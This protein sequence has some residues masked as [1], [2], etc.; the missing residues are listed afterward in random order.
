[1]SAILQAGGHHESRETKELQGKRS[2]SLPFL[3]AGGVGAVLSR[4]R[5]G[6]TLTMRLDREHPMIF[7][8]VDSRSVDISG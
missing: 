6:G 2:P 8:R 4:K 7:I 5:F 1:M 3:L